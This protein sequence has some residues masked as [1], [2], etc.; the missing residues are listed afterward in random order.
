MTIL[1]NN[2]QREGLPVVAE[3][4]Q[5]IVMVGVGGSIERRHLTATCG[6]HCYTWRRA[7]WRRAAV[8]RATKWS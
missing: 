4:L 2:C 8:R 5:R 1:K 6:V 7:R 3:Q